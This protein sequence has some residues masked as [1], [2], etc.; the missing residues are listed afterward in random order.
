MRKLI[1]SL[2]SLLLTLSLWAQ[3]DLSSFIPKNY[4]TLYG[5]FAKGDLNKDG[6]EDIALVLY[7]K[8]ERVP[9][10]DLEDSVYVNIDSLYP[11]L[12]VILFGTKSGYVEKTRSANAI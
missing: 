11:R 3:K 10:K 2:F 12:L 1:I 8:I 7:N 9:A 5:G 6:I 4:D